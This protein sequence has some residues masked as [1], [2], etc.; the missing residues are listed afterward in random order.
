MRQNQQN[1][2]RMR[3]RPNNRKAPNPLTRSFDSNGPDIKIRGT[4]LHIAEKYTQLARDA[5]SA[6]DRVM[7]ENYLQH[8]EHY[9]RIIAAAQAAQAAAAAGREDET[10]DEDFEPIGSDRFEP[11][12]IEIRQPGQFDNT[13]RQPNEQR[14]PRD[15][16]SGNYQNRDNSG[17]Q[18]DYNRNGENAGGNRNNDNNRN[19]D[20]AGGDRQ[21]QD[22]NE[23]RRDRRPRFD[24]FGRDNRGD[25]QGQG[26]N[27]DN[28]G[29]ERQPQPAVAP[30]LADAPQPDVRFPDVPQPVA[31]VERERPVERAP[32]ERERPA[33]RERPVPAAAEAGLPAFLLERQPRASEPAPERPAPTVERPAPA[34]EPVRESSPTPVAAAPAETGADEEAPRKRVPRRRA[35]TIGTPIAPTTR[36]RARRTKTTTDT[37]SSEG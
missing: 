28:R 23:Y 1:K 36:P 18:R 6:G 29:G 2:Q 19:G 37:E 35:T 20:N 11:R 3:G 10:E 27:Q 14:E 31:R 21:Q 22:R 34:A 17:P 16:G 13:N 33:E 9:Y 8:A 30:T 7:A 5:S 26:Q 24:R 32:V 4:A 15:M 12:Q 25:R